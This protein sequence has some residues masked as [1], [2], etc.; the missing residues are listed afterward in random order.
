M[1]DVIIKKYS[2]TKS[3]PI[4]KKKILI[5][6]DCDGV[7]LNTMNKAREM[8]EDKGYDPNNW[9][10]LHEF[11]LQ[12][13]WNKLIDDKQVIDNAIDKIKKIITCGKYDVKILTKLCGNETEETIKRMFFKKVL[14]NTEVITLDLREHKDEKVNPVDSILIEDNLNNFRRW[15]KANG[16]SVLFLKGEYIYDYP[17]E[18]RITE[19]EKVDIVDDIANFREAKSVKELLELRRHLLREQK[20]MFASRRKYTK[21]L[22]KTF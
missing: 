7:I 11:F 2:S 13:D 9:D 6:F 16:T 22:T 15:H 18:E 5:Y 21:M 20:R 10:S 14:P 4:I 3:K 17:D 8:A 1:N 19:D 12:V